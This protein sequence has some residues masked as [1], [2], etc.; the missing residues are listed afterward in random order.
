MSDT[1]AR[2][3]DTE[4]IDAPSFRSLL[5]GHAHPIYFSARK[6]TRISHSTSHAETLSAVGCT[7]TAQLVSHRFTEVFAQTLLQRSHYTP[8]DLLRLQHENMSILP[9]DH[10]TD[11]QA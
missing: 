4:W 10:V 2:A 11:C 5:S 6:A 3:G 8:T 1:V 9:I 7:Q